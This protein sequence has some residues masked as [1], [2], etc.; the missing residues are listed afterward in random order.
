M[1]INKYRDFPASPKRATYPDVSVA[2]FA[3][4]T[5]AGGAFYTIQHGIDTVPATLPISEIW[6]T[7]SRPIFSW[8]IKTITFGH[9]GASLVI[10]TSV[11]GASLQVFNSYLISSG[12]GVN[13]MAGLYVPGWGVRFRIYNASAAAVL[14][15][16]GMIKQQGHE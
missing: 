15:I 3:Q 16:S 2:Y 8:C 6:I 12:I 14:N 4:P 5:L 10:E 13:T 9:P 11:E 7:G 1:H